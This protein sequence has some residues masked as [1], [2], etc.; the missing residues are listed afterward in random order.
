MKIHYLEIVTPDLNATC[1]MYSSVYGISFGE[2]DPLLGNARTAE[3]PDG[4]IVGIRAPMH[5]SEAAVVRPYWL[6]ENIDAAVRDAVA[7]GAQIAHEPLE[8]PGKG[9]FAICI[10][11][12]NHHGFWQL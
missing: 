11:G 7:Q 1:D 2:P 12:D 3:M 6:V 10:I 4:S 5:E 8:I 9:K